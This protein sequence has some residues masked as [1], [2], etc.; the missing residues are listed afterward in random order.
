[1]ERIT[2]QGPV[3]KRQGAYLPHWTR[4]DAIYFVTFR[5]TDS[6]PAT[7]QKQLLFEREDAARSAAE[8]ERLMT[9]TETRKLRH[10]YSAKISAYLDAGHGRCLLKEDAAAN[11]VCESLLRFISVRYDL[12]AWCVMPNHVHVLIRPLSG[13]RL[14][15]IVHTWKSYTAHA[16]NKAMNERGQLWQEEYYDHMV[17]SEGDLYRCIEYIRTN[18]QRAGLHGWKWVG[19]TGMDGQLVLE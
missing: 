11:I 15:K 3:E 17:R 5:L 18:P 10:L 1:M 6:L 12:P 14:D 7:V 8:L 4:H 16:V 2:N 13:W 19:T 9:P